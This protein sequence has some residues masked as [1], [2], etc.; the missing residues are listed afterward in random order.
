[1][2]E[3]GMGGK[4]VAAGDY[5]LL[6]FLILL[7]LFLA[8]PGPGRNVALDCS[9]NGASAARSCDRGCRGGWIC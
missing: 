9:D 8:A 3:G 5:L 2:A 6:I 1:M 7:S 4:A